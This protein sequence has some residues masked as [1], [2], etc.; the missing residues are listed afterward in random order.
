MSV[1]FVGTHWIQAFAVAIVAVV[2]LTAL[3]VC[4]AKCLKDQPVLRHGVLLSALLGCLLVPIVSTY[5]RITRSPIVMI[6]IRV[7]GPPEDLNLIDK[8]AFHPDE[9]S[10]QLVAPSP[11]PA[12]PQTP[13][14]PQPVASQQ[15][16]VP[17]VFADR[18]HSLSAGRLLVIIWASGALCLLAFSIR[19][20]WRG[21]L[22]RRMAKPC[23][24][25]AI[26]AAVEHAAYNVGLKTT[27]TILLSDQVAGP[28]VHGCLRQAVILPSRMLSILPAEQLTDVLIHE[29]AHV[30]RRD[31]SVLMLETLARCLYWP[32]ITIHWLLREL[33]NAREEICDNYVVADRDPI[34]YAETLLNLAEIGGGQRSGV[35]VV[36][37]LNWRGPLERRVQ[38]ILDARRDH[39][40]RLSR[41]LFA[42]LLVSGL[43]CSVLISG[44]RLVAD[45]QAGK[46]STETFGPVG[47]AKRSLPPTEAEEKAKGTR[48]ITVIGVATDDDAKPVAGATVYLTANSWRDRVVAKATTDEAGKYAFNSVEFPNQASSANVFA[49]ATG[50][51]MTWH[52]MRSLVD[53]KTLAS[54]PQGIAEHS[55][56]ADKPIEMNLL[57]P[58]A[59]TLFGIIHDGDGKPIAGATVRIRQLDYL[60]PTGKAMHVNYREFNGL[61]LAPAKYRVSKTDAN[62]KFQFA[63]LPFQTLCA[64][65]RGACRLRAQVFVRSHHRQTPAGIRASEW[66]CGNYSKWSTSEFHHLHHHTRLGESRS[67][68]FAQHA[69]HHHPRRR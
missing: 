29:F 34:H 9:S 43:A 64:A 41:G 36:G 4:L 18:S 37:I 40:L 23:D 60:D 2:I 12:R 15:P 27:P 46:P 69:R 51:G 11:L 44:T 61:N 68:A 56:D 57:F 1:F 10:Q 19:G 39:S 58:K 30:Q 31:T 14:V 42:M 49:T 38:G 3:A 26:A 35:L 28:V 17:S 63:D 8:K 13:T 7:G 65:G 67:R 54:Y 20:Y 33:E 24:V 22:I 50:Y 45:D 62:G 32:V 16:A 48:S 5:A 25:Q 21:R 55:A 53:A 52:G 59:A 6:P 47:P 66:F